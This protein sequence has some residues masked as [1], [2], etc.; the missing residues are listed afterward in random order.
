M[1]VVAEAVSWDLFFLWLRRVRTGDV[2]DIN[3]IDMQRLMAEV[4]A[5]WEEMITACR[6]LDWD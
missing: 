2:V 4:G 3:R 1:L 6:C 5:G